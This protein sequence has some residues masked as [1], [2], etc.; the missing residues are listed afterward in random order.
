[1][2]LTATATPRVRLDI[3]KQLAM[4]NP[5][6]YVLYTSYFIIQSILNLYLIFFY[7]VKNKLFKFLFFENNRFLSS[8]NRPNLKYSVLPKKNKAGM[9]AELTEVI[10][11]RFNK[12]SKFLKKSLRAFNSI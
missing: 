6:W 11:Q 3:L 8:F 10:S 1:M 12:K 9:L 5:K 7:F 2:A 4:K